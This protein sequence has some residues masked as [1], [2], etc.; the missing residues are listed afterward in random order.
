MGTQ[1]EDESFHGFNSVVQMSLSIP[2]TLQPTPPPLQESYLYAYAT[3]HSTT[4]W[5]ILL[6]RVTWLSMYKFPWEWLSVYSWLHHTTPTRQWTCPTTTFWPMSGLLFEQL[7]HFKHTVMD[8]GGFRVQSKDIIINTLT[9][10]QNSGYSISKDLKL[11]NFLGEDAPRPPISQETPSWN[12]LLLS[13]VP[14]P[15]HL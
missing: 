5:I 7:Y 1:S 4:V 9:F 15:E 3:M 11:R 13:H 14:T 6:R 8:L 2:S 12:P 10:A